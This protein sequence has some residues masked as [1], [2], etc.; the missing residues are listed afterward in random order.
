[1]KLK[2]KV[3]ALAII[4][5]ILLIF[6]SF[7]VLS[8]SVKANN[9]SHPFRI[10]PLVEIDYD[11]EIAR[12]P[13]LPIN[14][15]KEIPIFLN[16][17][18]EGYYI[19]EMIDYL[20]GNN[21]LFT[22]LRVVDSPDYCEA[23]ITPRKT[24]LFIEKGGYVGNASLSLVINKTGH[25][26]TRGLVLIEVVT[27]PAGTIVGKNFT[28]EIEFIPGYLPF[29]EFETDSKTKKVTPNEI[30]EFNINIK[31]S[32]NAIT[33]VSFEILDKPKDWIVEIP[34]NIELEEESDILMSVRGP[35]SFGHHNDRESI[36]MKVV[37]SHYKN[38]SLKGKDYYLNFIVQS[39]GF[40]TPGFESLLFLFA[41]I[42]ITLI[43]KIKKKKSIRKE[44]GKKFD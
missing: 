32:G 33:N 31:N 22:D 16:L 34:K 17:T 36:T 43:F 13:L 4:F 29:L 40:S 42:F 25:A 5:M 26:L 12:D 35:K 6:N 11:Q 37:P 41:F 15:T 1:M 10:E 8:S 27:R 14:K 18:L 30:A 39:K 24:Q 20:V 21:K 19:D 9:D 38:L 28:K 23:A 44:G 2:T 3:R 7:I